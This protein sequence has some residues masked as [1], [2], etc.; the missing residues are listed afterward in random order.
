MPKM[1]S[2]VLI[3]A[4]KRPAIAFLWIT[5]VLVNTVLIANGSK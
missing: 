1:A 2:C 4:A 3:K 5:Q